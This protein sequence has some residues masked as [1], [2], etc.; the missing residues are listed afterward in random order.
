MQLPAVWHATVAEPPSVY[1][2]TL[3]VSPCGTGLGL[4]SSPPLIVMFA[5]ETSVGSR[6]AYVSFAPSTTRIPECGP[7][8]V[9]TDR[10]RMAREDERVV[11]GRAA[12]DDA[13]DAAAGADHE[14]VLVAGGADEVLEAGE[15]DA[16]HGAGALARDRPGRVGRR[17]VERV[18]ARAAV[19]R[20]GHRQGA[21]GHVEGVVAR[22][23]GDGEARHGCDGAARRDAV[24]RDDES[25]G[26]DGDGNGVRSVG[27]RDVPRGGR[28]GAAAGSRCGIRRRSGHARRIGAA[29]ARRSR[30]RRRVSGGARLAVA[31]SCAAAGA[32]ARARDGRRAVLRLR[33]RVARRRAC[34]RRGAGNLRR[35][36]GCAE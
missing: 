13:G 3:N 8:G 18:R 28:R 19:Q 4:P 9:E 22:A 12:V 5:P 15:G 16:G 27:E 11:A 17:A 34:G 32:G 25:V 20:D 29:G 14:G 36:R 6:P 21:R 30:R 2:E 10:A 7:V 24:D 26:G 33:C 35:R 31:R 23:A 1:G